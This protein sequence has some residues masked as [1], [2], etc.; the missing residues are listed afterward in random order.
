VRLACLPVLACDDV[1]LA[2]NC[3]VRTTGE[4]TYAL[5]LVRPFWTLLKRYPQLPAEMR[6]QP[7]SL[8]DDLRVPVTQGQDFLRKVV[9]LTDEE[10]LGLLAARETQLGTFD[11]LEYVAFSAS[12]WRDAIETVFRYIHLM[13]EAADFR[14]EVADGLA[15]IV[16][17]STVP[18]ARAGIDFQSAAMHLTTRRWFGTVLGDKEEVWFTYPQPASTAEHR[19]TFGAAKLRFDA[20]CN[21]FVYDAKHLDT[22]LVSADPSVHRVLREHVE[23]LLAQLAPGESLVE[24]VRGQLV[25]SLRSGPLGAEQIASTMGVTRRTLT[26]RLRQHGTTFT[27]LLEDVRH[28]AALHY[29][30]AS[31]HSAD[32]IAF[33]LGFSE[34]SA[35]VRAFKRWEGVAPMTYRRTQRAGA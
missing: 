18:L 17:D 30:S 3:G 11:V 28:Q 27:A 29:L 16:L 13:N 24:R 14:I 32:D 12:T 5:Q 34:S 26:R 19:A 23:S 9:Q 4:P 15:R 31:E 33:L 25:A 22:K 21:G 6:V 8:P 35:F 7:E 20:P 10:D 1:A 2:D